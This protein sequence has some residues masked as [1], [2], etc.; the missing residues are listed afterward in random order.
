MTKVY[1][2]AIR[3]AMYFHYHC[4]VALLT[5]MI[6]IFCEQSILPNMMQTYAYIYVYT[7]IFYYLHTLKQLL[8]KYRQHIS[9]I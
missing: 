8:L 1:T 4:K 3:I 9:A 5:T 6:V 7:R 2:F